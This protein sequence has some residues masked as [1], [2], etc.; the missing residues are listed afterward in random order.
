MKIEINP[1]VNN[2]HRRS[3]IYC[4]VSG[5]EVKGFGEKIYRISKSQARRI[6]Q[7]FCGV[8]GCGCN[9]GAAVIET[10]PEGTEYGLRITE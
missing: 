6:E 2:F 7:H 9:K 3:G 10:T 4:I 8:T 1:K 5:A